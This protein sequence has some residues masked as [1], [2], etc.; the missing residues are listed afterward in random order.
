MPRLLSNPGS[1]KGAEKTAI[2]I[3]TAERVVVA[4]IVPLDSGKLQA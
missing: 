1:D 4:E 2:H 3:L